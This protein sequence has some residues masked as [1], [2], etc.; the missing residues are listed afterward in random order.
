MC[1]IRVV[2]PV[3]LLAKVVALPLVTERIVEC[4]GTQGARKQ[5]YYRRKH[6]DHCDPGCG[7]DTLSLCTHL[8]LL[9][10]VLIKETK[11]FQMTYCAGLLGRAQAKV[12]TRAQNSEKRKH[13]GTWPAKD[14]WHGNTLCMGRAAG[15]RRSWACAGVRSMAPHGALAGRPGTPLAGV[16]ADSRRRARGIAGDDLKSPSPASRRLCTS[17]V[18]LALVP[19][20]C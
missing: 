9:P 2:P 5:S 6:W 18:Q 11:T 14:P 20:A 8:R 12:Q 10:N 1:W 19:P 7:S 15:T 4:I 13:W 3:E 16:Y 17:G